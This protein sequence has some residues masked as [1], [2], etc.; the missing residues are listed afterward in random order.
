MSVT[1]KIKQSWRDSSVNPPKMWKYVIVL[2]NFIVTT[3]CIGL[4]YGLW[5]MVDELR[6]YFKD[7]RYYAPRD[8]VDTKWMVYINV[9]MV[10]ITGPIAGLLAN[11]YGHRFIAFLG[12]A[13]STFGL[14]ISGFTK[15]V[16][17]LCF[18]YGIVTGA[19]FGL[20]LV[21][22][23]GMLPRYFPKR[24]TIA[25]AIA[26]IGTSMSIFFFPPLF[27]CVA[28]KYG[29]RSV[30][31]ILACLNAQ[32]MVVVM[33]LRNIHRKP[34]ADLEN[35]PPTNSTNESTQRNFQE[36]MSQ[37]LKNLARD[38]DLKLFKESPPFCMLV[39]AMFFI[40]IGHNIVILHLVS[41]AKS[42]G[43]TDNQSEFLMQMCG[44][45]MIAGQIIH[46]LLSLGLH[47]KARLTMFGFS[48]VIV[49]LVALLSS[50]PDTLAGHVAL[51]AL[52]GFLSGVY[53]PLIIIVVRHFILPLDAWR[54]TAAFGIALPLFG[55]GALIGLPVGDTLNESFNNHNSSYFLAG[56]ALMISAIMM[57][58]L[59][60]LR[61][62]QRKKLHITEIEMDNQDEVDSA[63][64]PP[65]NYGAVNQ[66]NAM[67]EN[68]QAL[69]KSSVTNDNY[70]ALNQS[71][72]STINQS[73]ASAAASPQHTEGKPTD[74]GKDNTEE[75]K[76]DE[77]S[78]KVNKDEVEGEKE[79][80]NQ[81]TKM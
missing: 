61:E 46:G 67:D 45:G 57:I 71:D 50:L 79:E 17:F 8:E 3:F 80:E 58:S 78:N 64:A 39:V 59:P 34:P 41:H 25:N 26:F 52:I 37:K 38:L 76:T 55:L 2:C 69:D 22:S 10:N 72:N 9:F 6:A 31:F 18:S 54:I 5:I 28:E 49:A 68:Y 36:R 40:G 53:F 70:Q 60:K 74:N 29:R 4:N 63:A 81:D 14:F 43:F 27:R 12:A 65:G 73:G 16:G 44:V 1:K 13:L 56:V 33:L 48:L 30:F 42:M 20:V 19:G 47:F 7:Y 15:S 24:Y 66:S 35:I 32:L 11:R 51:A 77:D 75:T 21:P 62:Q 23:L